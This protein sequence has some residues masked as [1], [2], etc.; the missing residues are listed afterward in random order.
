MQALISPNESSI[1]HVVSWD[2]ATPPNPVSEPYPNSCRVAQVEPD[3]QTF[4]VGDPMFWTSC[5][6]DVSADRFYYDTANQTINR[7]V[8]APQPAAADQPVS[9]GSQTL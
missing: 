2:T 6:D 5:A 1:Y 3:G 4:P 7:V 9:T 8:N